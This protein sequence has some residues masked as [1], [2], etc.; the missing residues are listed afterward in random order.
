MN[1]KSHFICPFENKV[2]GRSDNPPELKFVEIKYGLKKTSEKNKGEK[3][4]S[5]RK[6]KL[7]IRTDNEIN[8]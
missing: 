3:E 1:F 5:E 2:I 7:R 8:H 4:I 6:R